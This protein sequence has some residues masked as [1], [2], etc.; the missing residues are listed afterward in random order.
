MGLNIAV[1][2]IKPHGGTG[3]GYFE[4]IKKGRIAIRHYGTELQPKARA[5]GRSPLHDVYPVF[6]RVLFFPLRGLRGKG[7]VFPCTLNPF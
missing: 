2:L 3:K 5:T 7:F 6:L 1:G 4:P